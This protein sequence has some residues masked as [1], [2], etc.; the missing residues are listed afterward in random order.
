ML[1]HYKSFEHFP[2]VLRAAVVEVETLAQTT[3]T[4][5]ALQPLAHV[6][7]TAEFRLV[8][9]DL[10]PLLPEVALA[11]FRGELADRAVR[12]AR[13]RQR[14]KRETARAAAAAAEAERQRKFDM[15]ELGAMPLPHEV[16]SPSAQSAAVPRICHA[17]V[18]VHKL[19]AWQSH[20][21]KL[22]YTCWHRC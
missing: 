22:V 17:C 8:E 6:P 18:R 10:A 7:L 14:E 13:E 20:A 9:V 2:P 21:V 19:L 5:R 1:N 11:P 4:R 16:C 15:S 12:R 3:A